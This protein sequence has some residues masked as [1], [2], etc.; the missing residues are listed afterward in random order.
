MSVYETKTVRV[1]L[2]DRGQYCYL[3]L[4]RFDGQD[5]LLADEGWRSTYIHYSIISRSA[6]RQ[7]AVTG[8]AFA[9]IRENEWLRDTPAE[10]FIKGLDIGGIAWADITDE[11]H[12]SPDDVSGLAGRGVEP[13][14]D[15]GDGA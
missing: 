6:E 12:L 4:T 3:M 9:F 8:D 13:A 10:R 2:P 14:T 1:H 7:D 15:G 5:H 11:M